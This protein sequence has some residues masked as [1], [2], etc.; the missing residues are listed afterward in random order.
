MEGEATSSASSTP[1][2]R[3]GYLA[4]PYS[5][6]TLLTLIRELAPEG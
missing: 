3:A 6:F 2:T 1:T 5:P 4:K